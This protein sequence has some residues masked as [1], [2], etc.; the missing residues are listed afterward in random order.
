[1]DESSGVMDKINESVKEKYVK[2]ELRKE[3]YVRDQMR[4]D[5]SEA[6]VCSN[7]FLEEFRK[8]HNLDRVM[9]MV[10]TFFGLGLILL[11]IMANISSTATRYVDVVEGKPHIVGNGTVDASLVNQA[12]QKG[13]ND[14]AGYG[15]MKNTFDTLVILNKTCGS[16]ESISLNCNE[17]RKNLNEFKPGG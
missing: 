12:Y 7:D 10:A 6:D 5:D 14:G 11:L 15:I 16:A 13:I 8:S 2:D 9:V 17:I 3:K 1:M 4:E